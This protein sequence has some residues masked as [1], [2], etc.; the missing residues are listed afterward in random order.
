MARREATLEALWRCLDAGHP[1]I[2]C[3][4][5]N[6]T[7]TFMPDQ[8]GG[9]H[10]HFAVVEG[11]FDAAPPAATGPPRR[12]LIVQQTNRRAPI[13]SVWPLDVF[14]PSWRGAG[15]RG[16]YRR[17]RMPPRVAAQLAWQ[18]DEA[19][20]AG[21]PAA[22]GAGVKAGRLVLD[23]RAPPLEGE[24]LAALHR[25]LIAAGLLEPADGGA[26]R[27]APEQE[28]HHQ[29]ELR[30]MFIEVVPASHELS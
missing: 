9:Q 2:V 8:L 28:L 17:R 23:S 19:G 20:A 18:P 11:Y 14:E 4:D 7:H 13:P 29:D 26:V 27:L 25:E 5:I 22:A 1:A 6:N 16:R 21:A 12:F 24:A 15:W 10:T 3:V 30:Q